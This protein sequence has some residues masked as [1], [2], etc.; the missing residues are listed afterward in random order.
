[1]LRAVWQRQPVLTTSEIA[2]LVLVSVPVYRLRLAKQRLLALLQQATVAPEDLGSVHPGVW[3]L[4]ASAALAVR[5]VGPWVVAAP[6]GS[7]AQALVTVAPAVML[8]L[9]LATEALAAPV[10]LVPAAALVALASVSLPMAASVAPV[11]VQWVVVG[12]AALVALALAMQALPLVLP[13]RIK[14]A[15]AA[16]VSAASAVPAQQAS[17]ML[18]VAA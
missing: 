2:A 10:A 9:V 12:R 3:A 16:V 6:A 13:V 11:G 8:A 18:A 15:I 5:E 7:V 4:L 14:L 17:V 1:M